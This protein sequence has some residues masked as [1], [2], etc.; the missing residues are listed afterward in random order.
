MILLHI[1]L[2]LALAVDFT[3]AVTVLPKVPSITLN[4]GVKMPAIS[5]G[6]WQ[7]NA[8]TAEAA[9]ATA[10]QVGFRGIDDAFDYKN[11]VQ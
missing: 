11:Q 6:C 3:V 2:S 8:P 10:L 4:N 1:L 7:Y 9:I 5:A